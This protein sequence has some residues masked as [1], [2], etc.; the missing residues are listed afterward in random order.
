MWCVV[1]MT[2]TYWSGSV[3]HYGNADR[4]CFSGWYDNPRVCAGVAYEYNH[5]DPFWKYPK[6]HFECLV[7]PDSTREEMIENYETYK[8]R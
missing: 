3:A 4:D 5:Q 6:F 7:K 2:A 8:G 1:L